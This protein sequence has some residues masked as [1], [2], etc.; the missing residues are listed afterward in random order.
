MEISSHTFHVENSFLA[1]LVQRLSK[2]SAQ[3]VLELVQNSYDADAT[4][5]LV[6]F[7]PDGL[8]VE[9]DAGMNEEQI[10]SFH[11]VGGMHEDEEF[12]KSGRRIVGKYRFGR[13]LVLGVYEKMEVRTRVDSFVDATVITFQDLYRLSQGSV[14]TS[15]SKP[16]LKRTRGSEFFLSSRKADIDFDECV[17]LLEQQPFLRTPGFEVYVKKAD[18]FVEWDF[19][20]AK[21][22]YPREI[23]GIKLPVKI[24][25]GTIKIE[26]VITI[27]NDSALPLAEEDRGV[28]VVVSGLLVTRTYFGFEVSKYRLDRITGYVE[29]NNLHTTFGT[30][31]RLIEDENYRNFVEKMKSFFEDV[32]IP[33]LHDVDVKLINKTELKLLKKVDKVLGK[34][35][36][37]FDWLFP[38][39]EE[40]KK[41]PAVLK[42]L[43]PRRDIIKVQ[44]E[45][46]A[47]IIEAG[48]S[49]E[50]KKNLEF[51]LQPLHQQAEDTFTTQP[52]TSSELYHPDSPIFNTSSPATESQETQTT[53]STTSQEEKRNVQRSKRIAHYL[54][55]VGIIVM[56]YEDATD[57]RPSYCNPN[58]IL[59]GIPVKAV[60]INK[61]HPSYI[62]SEEKNNLPQHLIRLIT[63]EIIAMGY[64]ESEEAIR[65]ANKMYG[66]AASEL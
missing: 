5:V 57:E 14:T 6:T 66:L 50:E 30:K 62:R 53:P 58:F 13:L 42:S 21:R 17:K 43:L 64:K 20:N 47:I 15:I 12:T 3:A 10:R 54:H 59:Q 55:D 18:A 16:P 31:D 35:L 11:R 36:T 37:Q 52:T 2:N 19:R 39:Q 44:K 60:F 4:K 63:N 49:N 41:I 28:G 24:D 33:K 27:A 40:K 48:A 1:E 32:V 9:D 26:G 61:K 8:V 29:C 22:V 45:S 25:D 51:Q 65:I 7:L 23:P 34:V 38:V 46:S 56:F